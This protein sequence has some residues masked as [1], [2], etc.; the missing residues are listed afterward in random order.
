M[1]FDYKNILAG[2]RDTHIIHL[3]VNIELLRIYFSYFM[4][5][6]LIKIL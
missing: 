5:M 2:L 4:H 1:T 3:P 6:D